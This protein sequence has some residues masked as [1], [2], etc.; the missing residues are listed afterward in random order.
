MKTR[1][2]GVAL[3]HM[4]GQSDMTKLTVFFSHLFFERA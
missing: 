4:D 1:P 2:V 3:F